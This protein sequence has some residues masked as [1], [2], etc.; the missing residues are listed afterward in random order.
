MYSMHGNNESIIKLMNYELDSERLTIAKKLKCNV[1][2]T[3]NLVRRV[4][5]NRSDSTSCSIASNHSLSET[6][7]ICSSLHSCSFH[8]TIDGCDEIT[9]PAL[10]KRSCFAGT[11]AK[12]NGDVS[13]TKKK[14]RKL[15]FKRSS[16]LNHIFTVEAL[17]AYDHD[18]WWSSEE[19]K[20]CRTDLVDLEQLNL[21]RQSRNVLKSFLS[22]YKVLRQELLSF[23]EKY[24]SQTL[25]DDTTKKNNKAPQLSF[26]PNYDDYVKG[27]Q[28]GYDALER[29]VGF[30]SAMRRQRVSETVGAVCKYYANKTTTM[31]KAKCDYEDAVQ[32]Y[33]KSLT[34]VDRYWAKLSGKTAASIA[35]TT[36]SNK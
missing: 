33:C 5:R 36:T 3:F 11:R 20:Q 13:A 16:E 10:P 17:F 12:E 6:D 25:M 14:K 1:A 34:M 7:S 30:D 21:D 19:L 9:E 23:E 31:N 29:Y 18:L 32:Q 28:Y 35:A 24:Y 26:H 8:S 2:N 22:S 27:Y 15:R 4:K